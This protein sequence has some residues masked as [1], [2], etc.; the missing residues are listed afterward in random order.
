VKL[1]E[2][3]LNVKNRVFYSAVVA[4]GA[5]GKSNGLSISR[6]AIRD[7]EIY[8]KVEMKDCRVING[9]INHLNRGEFSYKFSY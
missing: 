6:R 7:I 1:K 2:W 4:N 8:Y 5:T 9:N 3:R